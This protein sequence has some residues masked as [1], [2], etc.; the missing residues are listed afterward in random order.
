MAIFNLDPTDGPHIASSLTDEDLGLLQQVVAV[1]LAIRLDK[2]AF[3]RRFRS[4]ADHRADM[5]EMVGDWRRQ[6]DVMVFVASVTSDL[7]Q[8]RVLEET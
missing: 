3:E 1:E 8:L 7:D 5:D 2:A 4:I 6:R